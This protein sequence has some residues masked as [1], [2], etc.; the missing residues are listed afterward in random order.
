MGS[1]TVA[2]QETTRRAGGQSRSF[3]LAVLAFWLLFGVPWPGG[4][5]AL[6][7]G[8]FAPLGQV[9][10]GATIIVLHWRANRKHQTSRREI[11]EGA[12]ASYFLGFIMTMLFLVFGLMQSQGGVD[13]RWI[14]EFVH[15]MGVAFS[16]SVVGLTIRQLQVLRRAGD[17]AAADAP[18][19]AGADGSIT[20][21]TPA[22]V[23]ELRS[24]VDRVASVAE[25]IAQRITALGPVGHEQSAER[26][27]SVMRGFE[28]RIGQTTAKL[29]S[30]LGTLDNPAAMAAFDK[31]L[32]ALEQRIGA[33]TERLGDAID[34][35]TQ[36]TVRAS[37]EIEGA[38]SRLRGGLQSD[39]ESL[40]SEV[41]RVVNEV[42]HGR[43]R[44]L[45]VLASTTA[46]AEE[47]QR[48]VATASRKQAA[49][50][51]EQMRATHAHLL[52]MRSSLEE[53]LRQALAALDRSSTSLLALSDA[54]VERANQL[55]NPADR[56]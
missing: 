24:E 32:R 21:D 19:G 37:V 54:V 1:G 8:G 13:A 46:Q 55:P 52:A 25:R 35:V 16:F 45:E 3:L 56:L 48:I 28:E 7:P 33:S 31:S 5:D 51:E 11:E 20:V 43:Q 41:A 26:M 29:E 15:D 12:D 53:E 6:Q 44:L 27:E 49:E 17:Y 50:W 38:S 40:A 23:A 22:A 14:A 36:S 18:I 34:G 39:L 30:A 2:E 10:V 9:M 42:A 4:L 47:T